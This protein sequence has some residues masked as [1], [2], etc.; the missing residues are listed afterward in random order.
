MNEL[1]RLR[2]SEGY[3]ACDDEAY[4]GER[5]AG[6][7]FPGRNGFQGERQNRALSKQRKVLRL[8]ASISI[9]KRHAG[10]RTYIAS[11]RSF[12]WNSVKPCET[13]KSKIRLM[14]RTSRDGQKN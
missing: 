4:Q 6:V 9:E 3:G 14:D 10:Q 2:G 12:S 13:A 11:R 7:R 8:H 1:S 5:N